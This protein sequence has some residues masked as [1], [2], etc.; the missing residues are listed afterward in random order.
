MRTPTW[1]TA[2]MCDPPPAGYPRQ[3]AHRSG[4]S[5]VSPRRDA[6]WVQHAQPPP[7]LPGP[8]RAPL[9]TANTLLLAQLGLKSL[10]P[11]SSGGGPRE[12]TC[13]PFPSQARRSQVVSSWLLPGPPTPT[14]QLPWVLQPDT[15]SQGRGSALRADF[16]SER[17]QE[18]TVKTA[19]PFAVSADSPQA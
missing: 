5:S 1:I 10:L 14:P 6:E 7:H 15:K 8:Q 3:Q 19:R 12:D 11:S 2:Y 18:S 16:S 4:G 9:I 17:P 13:L